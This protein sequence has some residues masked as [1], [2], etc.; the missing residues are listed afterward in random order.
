MPPS[1]GAL[2][3]EGWQGE[4]LY[5]VSPVLAALT[6]GR[7]EIHALHI[8]QDIDGSAR[9]DSVVL[10][11]AREAA[12]AIGCPVFLASKHD[13][14]LLADNRPHQ[15]LMLDCSPLEFIDIADLPPPPSA[16]DAGPVW[17]CLDEVTDPQNFGAALRSA[18]F[19]GAAGVLTC[20]RNSSPLSGVVSKASAGAMELFPGAGL[21][22]NV[23]RACEALVRIPGG[24][25]AA[26]VE[27]LNVS[28]ATG[29]LLHHL[30]QPGAAEAGQ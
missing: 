20:A 27:S 4:V 26:Q 5:G 21:R 13:L 25:G 24:A 6:A 9:K 17:L 18:F 29:I 19:L 15:G 28:V 30:L 1:S 22:T 2:L 12:Q 14:N 11:R 10:N 7:R 3:K 8:Q 23:R 16:Q